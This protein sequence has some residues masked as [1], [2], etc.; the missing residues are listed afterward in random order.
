MRRLAILLATALTA[1]GFGVLISATPAHADAPY[2]SESVIIDG[3]QAPVPGNLL[4]LC[5][6]IRELNSGP[7]CLHI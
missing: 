4:T 1:S 2:V 7:N 3:S 6:T 5:L